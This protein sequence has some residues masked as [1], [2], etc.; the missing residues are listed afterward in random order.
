MYLQF[1]GRKKQKPLLVIMWSPTNEKYC[2]NIDLYYEDLDTND[3]V[4][5]FEFMIIELKK[6]M[7][8]SK[9]KSILAQ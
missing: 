1:S 7:D 6:L 4:D 3:G 5:S 2:E 9:S 8:S